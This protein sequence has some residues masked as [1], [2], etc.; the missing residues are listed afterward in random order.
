MTEILRE[1]RGKIDSAFLQE[2]CRDH[3]GKPRSIC[4][5]DYETS[6]GMKVRS[7]GALVM[8]TTG[9]EIDY[10]TGNPCKGEFARFTFAQPAR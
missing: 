9:K 5:H 8:N 2:A 6:S 1:G 4:S 3:D 10:V 7:C